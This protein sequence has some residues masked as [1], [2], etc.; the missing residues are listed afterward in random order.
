[1]STSSSPYRSPYMKPI[2]VLIPT[3]GRPKL[4]ETALQSVVNQTAA[5]EIEE[6][7]VSE[8]R[9]NRNSEAVCRRFPMLPIRFALQ[10]PH[11]SQ[12]HNFDFLFN[13]AR[14]EYVAVLCDDDWW[15]SGHLHGAL[16]A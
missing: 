7:V 8:N 4:L 16:A 13:T 15:G 5:G 11:L 12:G 3:A 2:S 9:L 6:V 14:A 1:M 10:D